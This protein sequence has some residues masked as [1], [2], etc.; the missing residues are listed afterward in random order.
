[1]NSNLAAWCSNI[2]TVTKEFWCGSIGLFYKFWCN[3]RFHLKLNHS[4]HRNNPLTIIEITLSP[5]LIMKNCVWYFR[6][7][8]SYIKFDS[9]FAAN[10]KISLIYSQFFIC[11][12]GLLLN[13]QTEMMHEKSICPLYLYWLCSSIVTNCTS[14]WDGFFLNTENLSGFPSSRILTDT[15]SSWVHIPIYKLMN[16]PS[17][18][19]TL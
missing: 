18:F 9:I 14:Q 12:N 10:R 13:N 2:G 16:N 17:V 7:N 6:M 4:K 1:M 15:L 19:C 8:S 5:C 11:S 3:M